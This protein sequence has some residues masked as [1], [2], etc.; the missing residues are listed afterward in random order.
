MAGI[1]MIGLVFSPHALGNA[2]GLL[3]F[4][5]IIGLIRVL[6]RFYYSGL[7]HLGTGLDGR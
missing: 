1:F 2:S 4:L 7:Q 5:K 6:R 3:D